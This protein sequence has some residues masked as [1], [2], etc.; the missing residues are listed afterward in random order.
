MDE[1]LYD[2]FGNYIGPDIDSDDD[3]KFNDEY[4]EEEE[5]EYNDDNDWE[6]KN[7]NNKENGMD[8]E[9][10]SRNYQSAIVLHEDKK[11]Y[12]DADEVKK[13]KNKLYTYLMNYIRTYELTIYIYIYINY[14]YLS[15]RFTQKLK[16]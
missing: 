15:L 6:G 4:E 12:P 5:E 8:I 9:G 11:Y 3:N 10:E 16:L 13:K 14:L 2:E 1:D 7:K